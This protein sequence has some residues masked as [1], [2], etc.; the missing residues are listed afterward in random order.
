MLFHMLSFEYVSCTCFNIY[1]TIYIYG[2]STRTSC[3]LSEKPVD[4]CI[5][6]PF[7]VYID[8]IFM[9]ISF[10]TNEKFIIDACVDVTH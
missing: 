9:C 5:V 7:S 8:T 10:T 6:I 3:I 1:D 4:K 2:L